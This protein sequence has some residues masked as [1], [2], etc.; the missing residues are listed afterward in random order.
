M[1]K[2]KAETTEIERDRHQEVTDKIIA[3]MEQ[4]KKPWINPWDENTGYMSSPINVT[5][6]K[7]YTGINHII[8]M[9]HDLALETG[10]PRWCTFA[11]A[12]S[13]NWKIMKGAKS[14]TVFFYKKI[15]IKD[16]SAAD[17]DDEKSSKTIPILKAYPVFHASQIEGIPEYVRAQ[18]PKPPGADFD[19]TVIDD[20]NLIATNSGADIRTQGNRAYYQPKGDFIAMPEKEA[21][22]SPEYYAATL[23]H[24][25]GHWTSHA[26][27]LNRPIKF[28]SQD[29]EEYAKEELRA[30]LASAFIGSELGI[31]ADI[32]NHAS[33][34]DSWLRALRN[35]KREIFRAARDAQ[36]IADYILNFHP[37]YDF[38]IRGVN[39]KKD[40]EDNDGPTLGM[41]V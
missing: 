3:L 21:F 9:S 35:D 14:E 15:T 17:D 24:E 23:L 18:R 11:Q 8:L 33:Y 26:D 6:G 28:L 7:R 41:A 30:E 32:Q 5:T 19:W 31:T 29:K 27:R 1:A 22:L 4:G 34:I 38:E 40:S 16:K 36:Q 39:S 2:K 20:A 10:D 13:K 25:L 12:T 37:S